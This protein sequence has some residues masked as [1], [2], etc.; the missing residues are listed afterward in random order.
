MHT[1]QY[2]SGLDKLIFDANQHESILQPKGDFWFFAY[3]SLM[4]NPEFDYL[5]SETAKLYG[6]QRRLCL[7]SVAYRGTIEIP[8]LVMG[9]DTGGSCVGRALLISEVSADKVIEKLNQR[10]MVTGAYQSALK[11]VHLQSGER[12]NAVCL[13]ARRNHP[14]YVSKLDI[15]T[16]AEIVQHAEGPRGKNSEYVLNTVRHL[17]KM[18]I[19][20]EALEAVAERLG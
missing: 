14:Q 10:E 13:M 18:G 8:G 20:A 11:T 6:Y 19:V 2:A 15:P 9:L 4:W 5:R 3:G 12:V 7:W 1:H 16:T 17:R